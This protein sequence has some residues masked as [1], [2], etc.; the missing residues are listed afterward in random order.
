MI[1]DLLDEVIAHLPV[2]KSRGELIT[3]VSD[4]SRHQTRWGATRSTPEAARQD[5]L[6]PARI[7]RPAPSDI[8]EWYLANE[9]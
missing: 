5:E 1:C 4:R 8:V 3:L 2:G 9:A 6:V 7:S